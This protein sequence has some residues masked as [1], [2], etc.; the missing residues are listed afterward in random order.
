MIS[1]DIN[2]IAYGVQAWLVI[3]YGFS[4]RFPDYPFKL[5]SLISSRSN[6]IDTHATRGELGQKAGEQALQHTHPLKTIPLGTRSY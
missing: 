6:R 2:N 5:V 1:V 4:V 3:T